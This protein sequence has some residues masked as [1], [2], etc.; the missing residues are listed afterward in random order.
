VSALSSWGW[1]RERPR[2]Q[3]RCF[4]GGLY[5]ALRTSPRAVAQPRVFAI[6]GVKLQSQR[7]RETQLQLL[8]PH[9][10]ADVAAL[11]VRGTGWVKQPESLKPRGG[12]TAPKI[13]SILR[14]Q[15]RWQAAPR[16]RGH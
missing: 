12:T 3:K 5:G 11:L 6:L 4:L 16:M 9:A 2:T 15:E 14:L 8:A 13:A 7:A 10:H 1:E